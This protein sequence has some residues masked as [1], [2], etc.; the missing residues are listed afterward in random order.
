MG[1]P[2]K[3]RSIFRGVRWRS[4]SAKSVKAC[5]RCGSLNVQLSSKFDIWLTPEQYICKDCGYRGPIIV[6]VEE[7]KERKGEETETG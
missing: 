7:E 6:E 5:P 2:R 1:K 3:S 4:P